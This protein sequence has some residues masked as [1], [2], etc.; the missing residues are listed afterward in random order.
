MEARGGNY[1]TALA[2]L[3]DDAQNQ[4]G[5]NANDPN[6]RAIANAATGRGDIISNLRSAATD[7]NFDNKIR[8]VQRDAEAH[9]WTQ[10]GRELVNGMRHQQ[11]SESQDARHLG[12]LS[13]STPPSSGSYGGGIP[14]MG[15]DIDSLA[16]LLGKYRGNNSYNSH[17]MGA[18]MDHNF[19]A[20]LNAEDEEEEKALQPVYDQQ[21]TKG[22]LE[23]ALLREQ[24]RSTSAASAPHPLGSARIS[25][26]GTQQEP[27]GGPPQQMPSRVA[28]PDPYKKIRDAALQAAMNYMGLQNPHL[29][30]GP[31]R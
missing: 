17:A 26:P 20:S 30:R 27:A 21:L 11:S 16:A 18:G 22:N 29:L 10:E 24:L 2:K 6:A 23:N 4:G 28:A 5:A 8:S 14:S 25:I 3:V 1:N 12:G 7:S 13:F 15:S 9:G 31:T 19:K